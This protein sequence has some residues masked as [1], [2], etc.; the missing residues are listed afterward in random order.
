MG[1]T[2]EVVFELVSKAE[3]TRSE[4][5]SSSLQAEVTMGSKGLW[6]ERQSRM[7]EMRDGECAGTEYAGQDPPGKGERDSVVQHLVS[8][9]KAF[10]I[11]LK[12]M[13]YV[14]ESLIKDAKC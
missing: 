14:T 9:A 5:E 3:V 10:F 8:L 12:T 11:I 1:K 4:D 2:E 7:R 6:Q 13:G